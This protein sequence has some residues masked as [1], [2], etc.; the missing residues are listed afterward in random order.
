MRKASRPNNPSVGTRSKKA[1]SSSIVM[2]GRNSW[3]QFVAAGLGD[4]DCGAGGI[5][6]DFLPQ[7]VDVRFQRVRGD[8]RIVAPD[9]LQQHLARYR[10]LA[11]AIEIAQDR[12]LLFGEPNLVALGIE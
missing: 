6:L 10:P 2:H 11:G 8:A 5:P 7:P 3:H 12:G 4:Q 1:M 9:L